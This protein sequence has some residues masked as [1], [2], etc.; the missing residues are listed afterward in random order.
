[1]SWVSTQSFQKSPRKEYTLN[2]SWNPQYDLSQVITR[3]Y[4]D[5]KYDLEHVP[6]LG[7]SGSSGQGP[8]TSHGSLYRREWIGNPKEPL[9]YITKMIGIDLPGSSYSSII[10]TIFRRF[11]LEPLYITWKETY[12]NKVLGLVSNYSVLQTTNA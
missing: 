1:M 8:L 6:G 12:K 9:E 2:H 5:S 4:R 3:S 11:P 7:T 10:L